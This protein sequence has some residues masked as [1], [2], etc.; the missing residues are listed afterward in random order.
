CPCGSGKKYKQCCLQ[1]ESMSTEQLI[2]AAVSANGYDDRIS[3]V[4][5][6]FAYTF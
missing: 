3:D 1:K 5:F 4:L 2:R 6:D